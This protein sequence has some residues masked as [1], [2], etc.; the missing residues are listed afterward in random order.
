MTQ[1]R[2]DLFQLA[3]AILPIA[4]HAQRVQADIGTGHAKVLGPLA[5]TQHFGRRDRQRIGFLTARAT[6]AP[7]LPGPVQ[8]LPQSLVQVAFEHLERW[9]VPKETGLL[10]GQAVQQGRPL[11]RTTRAIRDLPKIAGVIRH[12]QLTHARAQVGLQKCS[13]LLAD[14]HAGALFEQRLPGAKFAGGHV[15]H[16]LQGPDA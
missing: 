4:R 16:R 14:H 5:V 1:L 6:Y 13:P 7:E 11:H 9:P 8:T 3:C 12:P 15:H 10:H 2:I